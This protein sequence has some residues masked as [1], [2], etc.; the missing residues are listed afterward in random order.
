MDARLWSGGLLVTVLVLHVSGAA[1][2]VYKS[3]DENGRVVF[4]QKPPQDAKAEV[5]KPRYSKPPSAP[6][7]AA[8]PF[9][10]PAQPGGGLPSATDK[11]A[12]P[13]E[14][15]PEQKA[16]KQKNCA[17]AHER[18]TQLTQ[19]RALRLRYTNEQGQVADLT[20]ELLDARIADAQAKIAEFCD[21]G[22]APPESAP[23]P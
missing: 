5:I 10:P 8:A 17:T 4:S 18:L 22:A 13:Q 1:A 6:A 16:A 15:T 11:T 7:G 9:Q 20:P 23:A 3:I 14:L 21:A 19:P 2:E 12:K